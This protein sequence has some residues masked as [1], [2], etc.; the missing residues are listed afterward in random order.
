MAASHTWLA[1]C[2]LATQSCEPWST[3][4]KF[5]CHMS[6]I[7]IKASST[8]WFSCIRSWEMRF[9]SGTRSAAA[10]NRLRLV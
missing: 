1:Q 9:A 6:F 4:A 2:P 3:A 7:I 10:N 8:C 5:C